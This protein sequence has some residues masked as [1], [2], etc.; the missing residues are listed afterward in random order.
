M[1]GVIF[2]IFF[3]KKKWENPSFL[4]WNVWNLMIRMINVCYLSDS[5][6]RQNTQKFSQSQSQ[7][8]SESQSQ[9][10]SWADRDCFSSS[11]GFISLWI[12][13]LPVL[14]AILK[15]SYWSFI[16]VTEGTPGVWARS[17]HL[18][19]KTLCTCTKHTNM[20]IRN[21]LTGDVWETH[22]LNRPVHLAVTFVRTVSGRP[23][24]G[25]E[26]SVSNWR[27]RLYI[28]LNYHPAYR[29]CNGR[30]WRQESA[31]SHTPWLYP[32]T[33]CR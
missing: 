21:R 22:C 19:V 12:W 31:P 9:S 17:D 18:F 2:F 14:Q 26:Y 11:S 24:I 20:R 6:S 32:K 10:Y 15:S 27:R 29:H 3:L 5:V 4:V 30:P 33:H 13:F 25:E 28:G 1:S 7:S 8:Q 23:W 16:D